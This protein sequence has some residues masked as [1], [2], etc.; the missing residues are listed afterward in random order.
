M[1]DGARELT[2]AKC[3]LSC[4]ADAFDGPFADC[5][6][7]DPRVA[8]RSERRSPGEGGDGSA[9]YYAADLL[10]ERVGGLARLARPLVERLPTSASRASFD[11][12]AKRFVRAAHLP[13]LERHHGWKEIFSPGLRAELTGRRSTFDPVDILRDRYR[14]TE[15]Q[16]C[17]VADVD[18]GV[19]L[20][21][22]TC[23][24]GPTRL[25]GLARSR[26][27]YLDTVVTNLALALPPDTRS[28]P[29]QESAAQAAAPLCKVIR[30]RGF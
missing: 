15:A 1:Q 5:Q 8:A 18:L 16:A 21:E 30:Q 14:E 13:S 2:Y 11:Y 24:S 20:V 4:L 12:K 17:P 26:V 22:T 7:C 3:A 27:P 6:L 29:L 25:D 28:R 23:S 9:A 19:Y 10:A